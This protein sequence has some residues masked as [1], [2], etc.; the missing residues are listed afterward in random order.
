M[1]SLERRAVR[2]TALGLDADHPQPRLHRLHRERDARDE[3][4]AAHRHDH[5]VAVGYL[6]EH[7]HAKRA[8]ARD[9]LRI[10]V[11]IDVAQVAVHLERVLLRLAN[12]RTVNDHVCTKELALVDLGHRR[13][14]GHYDRHRDAELHAVPRECKR[15]VA[16]RRRHHA[17]PPSLAIQA[18]Q[19]VPCTPFL[20]GARELLLLQLEVHVRPGD[21]REPVR[22]LAAGAHDTTSNAVHRR[23]DVFEADAVMGGPLHRRPRSGAVGLAW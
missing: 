15:M 13:H 7:L 12:V 5:S 3:P 14:S 19:R 17:T 23:R 22:A 4:S 1:A 9:N 8:G 16:R 10:V 6:L 18:E 20:E 21:L 11:P 2:G